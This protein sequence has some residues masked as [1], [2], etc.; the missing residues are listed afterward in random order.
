MIEPTKIRVYGT[1]EP[2]PK[3]EMAVI[4]GKPRMIARD[5]R[6]R[7]DPLGRIDPKTGKARIQKY[8]RGYKRR[9]MDHIVKT[10][11][12]YMARTSMDQFTKE[13]SLAMGCIFYIKKAKSCKLI[14][15]RQKPDLDNYIY[16]IWNALGNTRNKTGPGKY[17]EG[18][19]YY[20]DSQ[21]V[22]KL[23]EG[24]VWATE[25]EPPGVLISVCDALD[26]RDEIETLSNTGELRLI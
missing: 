18:V 25:Q 10:V 14:F 19:L 4:H 26:I 21:I 15:P 2:F 22:W 6:T 13:Y 8:D 12:A 16:A 3:K 23:P 1:P 9:W 5:Y 17:P 11:L 20:D 24:E 7:K